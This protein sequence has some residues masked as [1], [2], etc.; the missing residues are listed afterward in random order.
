MT[1][2]IFE[3][4]LEG[5][6]TARASK[7]YAHRVLICA[8]LSE[9]ESIIYN[10]ETS[11]DITATVN[12]L[13]K[14]GATFDFSGTTVKVNGINFSQRKKFITLFCNESGSTLRFLIPLSLIFAEKTEFTGSKRLLERPQTVYE[15]LLPNKNC[16]FNRSENRIDV[17]GELSSGVYECRGDV[18]SQFLTGLLFTLPL[19][20]GDSTIILTT[21]LQSVP[22]VDLTIDVL[23]HFGVKITKKSN[24]EYFIKGNQKFASSDVFCEGDW[25]NAAFLDAFNLLGGSVKINGLNQ[26]SIQGDKIYQKYFNELKKGT[27]TLDITD[28][29]DLAPILMTLATLLNGAK[30]VGT[31]RLKIKESDRGVVMK[32]ELLKFG[33]EITVSEDE[34]IIKKA[35]LHK[36][37]DVLCGNNDHRILM[38]LAVICS[39]LGGVAE[40]CE[41]VNKS[42]PMFFEDAQKLGLNF[43]II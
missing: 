5:E 25:S 9:G 32:N 28:Y 13:K 17:S 30:L 22:Y 43:K 12:C 31:K 33:A 16:K 36:P 27:P 34:I 23:N 7:S 8:A 24:E 29:P 14:L 2:E 26:S 42:Y 41:C 6:I 15:E 10:I 19:L 18:S 11:E 3:S 35:Q 37:K 40:N 20:N 1:A 39:A 21:P 38:S 4:K